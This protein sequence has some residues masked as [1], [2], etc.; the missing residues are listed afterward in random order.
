MHLLQ[1]IQLLT[2]MFK[3]LISIFSS[4]FFFSFSVSFS[5]TRLSPDQ[6]IAMIKASLF[7]IYNTKESGLKSSVI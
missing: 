6:V 5:P 7:S 1:E 4:L 2:L 3:F